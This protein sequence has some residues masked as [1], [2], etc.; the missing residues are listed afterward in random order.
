MTPV[1]LP[2]PARWASVAGRAWYRRHI[3]VVLAANGPMLGAVSAARD[4]AIIKMRDQT[5]RLHRM[6][7]AAARHQAVTE[8]GVDTRQQNMPAGSRRCRQRW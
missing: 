2:G 5:Q 4:R 7:G 8:Q 3:E 6:A 1:R